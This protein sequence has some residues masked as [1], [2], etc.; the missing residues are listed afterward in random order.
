VGVAV[1]LAAT[2]VALV[3][4]VATEEEMEEARAEVVAKVVEM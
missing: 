3:G 2:A 1:A 4:V